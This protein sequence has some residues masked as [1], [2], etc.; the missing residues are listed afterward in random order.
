MR[1]LS[2]D[3]SLGQGGK[4]A[5]RQGSNGLITR[6]MSFASQM[7]ELEKLNGC[8][9]LA[10]RCSLLTSRNRNHSST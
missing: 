9:L 6:L 10:V 8:S 4:A 3:G 2:F 7:L 5:R 1:E